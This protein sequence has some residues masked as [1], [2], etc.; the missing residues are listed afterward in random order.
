MMKKTLITLALLCLILVCFAILSTKPFIVVKDCVGCKECTTSCPVNAIHIVNDKAVIDTDKC[1]DCKICIKT[2][3]Y[4]A[5][6][7]K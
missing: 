1:I 3:T 2:C 6:R 4:Q 7:T 5:I